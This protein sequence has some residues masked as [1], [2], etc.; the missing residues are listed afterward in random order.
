MRRALALCCCLVFG[1]LDARATAAP[2][3][4]STFV[5]VH[6]E[7]KEALA[8]GD[9][10]LQRARA[11]DA[12][13]YWAEAL[14]AWRTALDLS[15]TGDLVPLL[16]QDEGDEV[17]SDVDGSFEHRTEGVAVAVLRRL[18][19]LPESERARWTARFDELASKR[20]TEAR[21]V[22]ALL[23]RIE[24]DFPATSAA[25]LASLRL[26]DR[27]L[28]AGALQTA[29]AW[30][31]RG[32]T[33]IGLGAGQ[34]SLLASFERRE[35]FITELSPP[36]SP[37][38]WRTATSLKLER[39]IDL[40]TRSS[41]NRP[42]GEGFDRGL[43]QGGVFLAD[44]RIV[45]HHPAAVFVVDES[46]A[47]PIFEPRKLLENF[48]RRSG[49]TF[50]PGGQAWP[51]SPATD[52]EDLFF[53]LGRAI[54][55]GNTSAICRL[56]PPAATGEAAHLRWVLST[57]GHSGSDGII[58]PLEEFLEP[59]TWEFQPGPVVFESLLIVQARQ[60][61]PVESG[62]ATSVDTSRPRC[63]A[64]ALD[65]QTGLPVW[66]RFLGKGSDVQ[67]DFGNRFVG[68][69]RPAAPA[70]PIA[71]SGS[72]AFCATGVGLGVLLDLTDG[73]ILW[74]FG[75]ERRDADLPGW[76]RP[77]RPSFVA[78][79]G[80]QS[81]L[82]GPP[83]SQKL[84]WLRAATD[85]NGRGL[86]T[87]L[88][89]DIGSARAVLASGDPSAILLGFSGAARSLSSLDPDTG[90]VTQALRLRR[91]EEFRGPSLASESRV[92]LCT[93][94]S[95]YLFDR[96]RELLLLESYGLQATDPAGGG[97]VI[98]KDNRVVVLGANRV[99]IFGL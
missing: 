4:A 11:E 29:H 20:L 24:R 56:S 83:D 99:F 74:T 32:R 38:A 53:V 55:A 43:I 28:E 35:A 45:I 19:L 22:T 80:V 63:F 73:R 36:P 8:R 47:G 88:P 72:R 90:K 23:A 27:E 62:A 2:F 48:P 66:T 44:G 54:V 21:S 82:W 1:T 76:V 79:K 93:D 98:A 97:T 50:A 12:E 30:L 61:L 40:H 6:A 49:A 26:A 95:L 58:T 7:A 75:P 34:A 96:K 39:E 41:G 46:G 65:V 3:Q 91:T 87:H 15:A 86:L 78:S 52:G 37:A 71:L 94:R 89:A 31:E 68:G 5:P 14:D 10:S 9:R 42:E 17:W 77:H 13:R 85:L 60:W 51:L 64:L 33:H 25:A 57:Q 81:V 59:G 70:Q 16:V 84:Y 92:F 67:R 18:S 69:N